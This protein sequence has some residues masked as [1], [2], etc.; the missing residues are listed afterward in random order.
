MCTRQYS[1]NR[2][3][4]TPEP[5]RPQHTRPVACVIA[6]QYSST[7]F[8]LIALSFQPGKIWRAFQTGCLVFLLFV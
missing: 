2:N 4:N 3:S 6:Q 7:I 5:E 1:L 8:D